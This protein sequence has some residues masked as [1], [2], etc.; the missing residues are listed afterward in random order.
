LKSDGEIVLAAVK[1]RG[2]ALQFAS[3][4]LKSDGEIVLA[5]VKDEGDAL[6]YAAD[7]LRS[8]KEVVHAAVK[9]RGAALQYAK[10]GLNQDPEFLKAAGLFD[11]EEHKEYART[12]KATLSVKFSL[13]EQSTPYATE[14]AKFMKSDDFLKNFKTYNPNAWCKDSCDPDFTDINHPC[15]GSLHT[16]GFLESQNLDSVTKRPCKKTC[17]RFAFRF[18]QQES[19]DT[20]G[21]MIQVEEQSG[22]G[23][24]QK[25]ET[26]MA[27]EVGLKVFRTY[28]DA[29]S[30]SN[31]KFLD[32]ISTA[33]KEW[34]ESGCTNMKYRLGK[35]FHR[36]L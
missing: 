7:N 26:E 23:D 12:E 8:D 35:R 20:N 21:F 5:A 9:Q 27:R 14:F 13:A 1:S 10:D 18:H 24:G 31:C 36:V 11:E 30:F 3:D 32:Q 22:L 28:T 29:I 33:V 4:T 16:C 19:K 6:Q 15:R 17:W 2:Y 25:I 34:Y